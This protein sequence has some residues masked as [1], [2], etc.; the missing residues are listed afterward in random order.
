MF[1]V[2]GQAADDPGDSRGLVVPPSYLGSLEQSKDVPPARVITVDLTAYNSEVGQCD[3][4]PFITANGTHVRDGI[5]ATNGL[6]FHTKVRIPALFGDKVFTVEDRMNARYSTRI[7]IWM[8]N[9]G[10]AMKFG[11]KRGVKVEIL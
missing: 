11:I 4:S 3:D 5:I 9:H 10:D 7:D 1:Q 8:A 6:P 2:A